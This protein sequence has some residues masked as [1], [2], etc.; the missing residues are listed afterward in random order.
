MSDAVLPLDHPRYDEVYQKL[1]RVI[2]PEVGLPIVKMGLLYGLEIAGDAVRVRMTLTTRGCPMGS[3]LV[4]G[5]KAVVAE[6]PWVSE[7]DVELVWEPAW[8]PA[9]IR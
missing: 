8:S 4:D 9:M 1:K 5:V 2:D 3:S 7:V 6:L